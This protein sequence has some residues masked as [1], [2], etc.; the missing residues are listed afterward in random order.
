LDDS[1][2][3][4]K[5]D[6][7]DNT[8]LFLKLKGWFCESQEATDDWRIEAE[9]DFGFPAGH[10]W[11]DE[12]KKLLK[13][14][15]RPVVVFNRIGSVIS[16]VQGTE[17]QNR[18]EITFS[19]R[20]MGD[21]KVNE[22][23]SSASDW[24]GQQ[25]NAEFTQ[26]DAFGDVTICGM[27]WIEASMDYMDDPEGMYVENRIDPLEMYWDTSARKKN[28]QDA[29]FIFRARQ[30]PMD[31]AK[32]LY[33]DADPG[34]LHAAWANTDYSSS[35]EER[36][37]APEAYTK[38]INDD[39]SAERKTVTIVEAQWWEK[40]TYYSILDPADGQ[41]KEVSPEEFQTITKRLKELGQPDP[42]K[43]KRQ[44]KVFHQA[45]LGSEI[46]ETTPLECGMF[47]YV[48]MTGKRDRNNNT[49]YG[50][51]R[52]MKDPQRWANKWLSQTM[53]IVN[54]N[55]KGSPMVEVDAVPNMTAFTRDWADPTKPTLLNPGALKE[56]KIQQRQ[57]IVY[58]AGLDKL[59]EFAIVS[60]R[61]SSGVNLELLGLADRDQAGV[62]ENTRK[63]AGL[64]ILAFLFDALR[65]A[66]KQIGELRL[67]YI[68]NYM[69][70]GRLIRVVGK[71]QEQYVP[72]TKDQTA[73]E[74]DVIVDESPTSPN[75]KEQVL[76]VLMQMLPG[77]MK[78]GVPVPPDI[79]DY[80]PL[81]S[82]MIESWKKY[83]EEQK[84]QQAQQ[85]NPEMMQAQQE[86]QIKQQ[87]SQQDMQLKG[88]EAMFDMNLQAQ[89]QQGQMQMQA[90]GQAMKSQ[91]A[92]SN[93]GKSQPMEMPT[94]MMTFDE[95]G[96]QVSA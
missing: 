27:G 9:E 53:H 73:G 21:V 40:E 96:R 6:E 32:E 94:F 60:I 76:A 15:M 12:E 95:N 55:A 68:Q 37:T 29:R 16:A 88:M 19:P 69:S 62:L 17:L 25:C 47:K 85:P 58:P 38:G 20:D 70:D 87:E 84:Q 54:S 49:Y 30:M 34:I 57:G 1:V 31:E 22:V 92:N 91:P 18:Q 2:K 65:L 81:P 80:M 35:T 52:D 28:L 36:P 67:Y 77:L 75:Q 41:L 8:D 13:D 72:L 7:D 33:P 61:D 86:M 82:A 78:A 11:T 74:Y 26:S 46:I 64:T 56:G 3:P 43:V 44:R 93:S 14:Q 71:Q 45:F 83:I 66:R 59:M 79:L 50:L 42:K 23:V 4:D 51:V 89:K 90:Q 63:Q 48:A 39:A 5:P 24:M 10:Q